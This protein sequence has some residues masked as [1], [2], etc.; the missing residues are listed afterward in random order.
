MEQSKEAQ[1]VQ[2]PQ[3]VKV[4]FKEQFD[5]TYSGREYVYQAGSNKLEEGDICV[6]PTIYGYAIAAVSDAE[7]YDY[8]SDYSIVP[9]VPGKRTLGTVI[10]ILERTQDRTEKAKQNLLSRIAAE[11][12]S[13]QG[14]GCW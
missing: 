12:L 1:L 4:K 3:L 7:V 13:L 8:P 11:Q 5:N 9:G 10:T 2:L 14:N 6:V